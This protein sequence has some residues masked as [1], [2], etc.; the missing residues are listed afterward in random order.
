MPQKEKDNLPAVPI[1]EQ[2]SALQK[3]EK[4]AEVVK[5][6]FGNKGISVFDLERIKI[7]AGGMTQWQVVDSNGEVESLKS[8]TCAI[9]YMRNDKSYWKE[10]FQETGGG[11]PPN[12]ISLDLINQ[13]EE[14]GVGDNGTGL[15]EHVCR[16]CPQNQWGSHPLGGGG[17]AC[18]ETWILFVLRQGREKHLFP[19]ILVLTP[20]S[21]K[22]WM[23]YN[24][25]LTSQGLYYASVLHRLELQAATSKGGIKYAEVKPSLER[26]LTEPELDHMRR[27]EDAVKGAF[28]GVRVEAE[29]VTATA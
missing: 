16:T 12:C 6:T 22:S 18:R 17:K 2:F 8:I 4:T 28:G 9:P 7:P 23:A 13:A 3:A 20:G 15:G 25:S 24:T 27:Y 26:E 5:R 29:D 10:S 11:R 19:S 21:L 1:H 14:K